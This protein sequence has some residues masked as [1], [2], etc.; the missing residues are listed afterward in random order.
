MQRSNC[1]SLLLLLLLHL[2]SVDRIIVPVHEG[3]HWTA[4]MVDL[5]N[6]RFVFFDSLLGRNPWA[7]KSLQQ[8][9]ADEAMVS[10]TLQILI[11]STH[12]ISVTDCVHCN[13]FN[14][15]FTCSQVPA[16]ELVH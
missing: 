13:H 8:W 3:M 9:L 11:A 2:C 6:K 14:N 4:A 5:L 15:M 7:L 1:L 12:L 10:A 16:A